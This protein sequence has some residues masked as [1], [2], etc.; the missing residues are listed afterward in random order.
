MLFFGHITRMTTPGTKIVS[1]PYPL[2]WLALTML[3]CGAAYVG[4]CVYFSVHWYWCVAGVVFF[5]FFAGAVMQQAVV[6]CGAQVVVEYSR[7]FG[8][9]LLKTEQLPF[10]DYEAVCY[11]YRADGDEILVGLRH[12]SKRTIWFR[13]FGGSCNRPSRAAEEFAWKLSCDTGLEID[14]HVA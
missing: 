14:D 6:D 11:G 10:S 7:L 5:L 4:G 3:I 9:R 12:R 1:E 13:K 8:K 2:N